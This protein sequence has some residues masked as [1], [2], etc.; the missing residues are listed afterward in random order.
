MLSG[1]PRAH[2]ELAVRAQGVDEGMAFL[3]AERSDRPPLQRERRRRRSGLRAGLTLLRPRQLQ[4]LERGV[5]VVPVEPGH[6]HE[7]RLR[8]MP[9]GLRALH[10][11]HV[12][13]E[14]RRIE[15]QTVGL[16][17]RH[18]RHGNRVID[19]YAR[20]ALLRV[21]QREGRRAAARLRRVPV[22]V[23]ARMGHPRQQDQQHQWRRDLQAPGHSSARARPSARA[24]RRT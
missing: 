14:R 20:G 11:A 18:V 24:R 5:Q 9:G 2:Q 7:V 4:R 16:H 13:D 15:D 23:P 19:P 6:A 17:L 8:C 1:E 3:R 12:G 21:G 10:P 22:P